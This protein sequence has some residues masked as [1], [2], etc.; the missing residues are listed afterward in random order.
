MVLDDQFLALVAIL[1]LYWL[2]MLKIWS[3]ICLVCFKWVL[4]MWRVGHAN[5]IISIVIVAVQTFIISIVIVAVQTLWD[6]WFGGKGHPWINGFT[7]KSLFIE[8]IILYKSWQLNS[9]LS[10]CLVLCYWGVVIFKLQWLWEKEKMIF[11]GFY[12]SSV[13]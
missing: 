10:L 3:Q 7:N 2:M 4:T 13:G 12:H 6:N 1:E 11:E 8:L 9:V 5:I